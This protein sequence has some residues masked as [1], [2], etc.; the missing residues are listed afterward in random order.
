MADIT[1]YRDSD[2]PIQETVQDSDGTATDVSGATISWMLIPASVEIEAELDALVSSAVVSKSVG[3][4]VTINDGP[5]GKFRVAIDPADTEDLAA[6]LYHVLARV[7][8]SAG[9]Q[10][11][12]AAYV[13]EVKS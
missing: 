3:S 9:V 13:A 4:G 11:G 5:N 12:L 7:K 1:L 6:G 2:H 10:L 8:T